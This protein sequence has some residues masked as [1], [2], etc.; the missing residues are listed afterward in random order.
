MKGFLTKSELSEAR[1]LSKIEV[2]TEWQKKKLTQ[3]Y[4]KQMTSK[5]VDVFREDHDFT[6][7]ADVSRKF[8]IS[9]ERESSKN[10]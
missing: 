6:N 9:Y 7:M 2:L 8:F 4:I 10:N 1:M 3:L 5:K